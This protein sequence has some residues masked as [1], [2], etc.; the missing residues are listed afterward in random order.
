MR[1]NKCTVRASEVHALGQQLLQE[2]LELQDYKRSLTAGKLASLLLLVACWQT[3]LSGVCLL[4]KDAPS[5]ETVRQA[6]HACLPPRPNDL[7]RRLL[8]ALWSLLPPHLRACPQPMVID[9]HQRPYY[10]HNTTGCTRREKK[11]S[12]R[13]SFTYATLAVLAPTGRFTVGLLLTRAHMRLTTIIEELLAQAAEAGLDVSYL[14]LDKE[15]YAAEV[16]DQLKRRNLA[17]LMPVAKRGKKAGGGNQ[18]LFAESCPV[19]WHDYEWTTPR[20]RWDFKTRKRHKRGTV[21]V[22]VQ[23]CVARQQRTGKNLV[24]ASWGLRKWP[25]ALVVS[26]YRRRFGIE[27]KYRQLGQCLGTTSTHDERV[28]LLL[29]GVALLLCSLWALLHAEVF[30]SGPL[31]E[32]QL[33]LSALRLTTL[34][35]AL[36]AYLTTLFGG[37][38][39]EWP[40]QRPI[41]Q[42]FTHAVPTP[43]AS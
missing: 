25:P 21:T 37:V 19:G 15:F 27:A 8:A 10:G 42:L 17:F 4:V 23:I 20:R 6:V 13:K 36:V 18:H 16:I 43:K 26:I 24:Y 2:H 33:H 32:R 38:F 39:D 28:R 12:T 1:H 7:R 35:R 31:G 11:K 30:G 34:V 5:H 3:S 22:G 41:P 29:V 9:L 14:L 40:S